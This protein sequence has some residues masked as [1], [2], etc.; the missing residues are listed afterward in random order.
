M[1]LVQTIVLPLILVTILQGPPVIP[2]TADSP[3]TCMY[4]P[5]PHNHVLVNIGPY[6][7]GQSLRLYH[8]VMM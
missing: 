4:S 5:E 3:K 1:I 2:E 7:Q 6:I 8:L